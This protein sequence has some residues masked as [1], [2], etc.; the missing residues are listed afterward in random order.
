MPGLRFSGKVSDLR[1][2]LE[3]LAPLASGR[4]A[5]DEV[6]RLRYVRELRRAQLVSLRRHILSGGGPDAA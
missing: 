3:R 1:R 2:A 6:N 4:L 5:D